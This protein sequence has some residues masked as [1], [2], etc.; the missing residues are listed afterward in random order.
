MLSHAFHHKWCCIIPD[1][2]HGAVAKCIVVDLR[3]LDGLYL[4]WIEDLRQL[5]FSSLDILLVINYIV[6]SKVCIF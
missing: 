5:I 1:T 2:S 6:D 3:K 4:Y